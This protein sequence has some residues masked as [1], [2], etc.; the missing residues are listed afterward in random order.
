MASPPRPRRRGM[1]DGARVQ[2]LVGWSR[3]CSL[4][5]STKLLALRAA[6]LP[7]WA[8]PVIGATLVTAL[9]GIF[10][11]SSLW[12]FTTVDFPALPRG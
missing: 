12:F 5:M 1:G 11:T 10:L 9:T 7:K 8:V 6:R 3:I 2:L 4:A